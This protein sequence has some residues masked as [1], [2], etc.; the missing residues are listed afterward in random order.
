MMLVFQYVL[1]GTQK[2][3]KI[4][5]MRAVSKTEWVSR[6]TDV[7]RLKGRQLD[8]FESGKAP[9]LKQLKRVTLILLIFNEKGSGVFFCY[10]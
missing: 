4:L 5:I 2:N 1:S 8:N 10:F 7:S 6:G 3:P 9:K